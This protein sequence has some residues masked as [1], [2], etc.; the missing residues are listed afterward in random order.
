MIAFLIIPNLVTAFD[1]HLLHINDNGSL[2]FLP[3]GTWTATPFYKKQHGI[4]HYILAIQMMVACTTLWPPW[5]HSRKM[6]LIRS[7]F[8]PACFISIA[9]I[10]STHT[11]LGMGSGHQAHANHLGTHPVIGASLVLAALTQLCA[12][13]LHLSYGADLTEKGS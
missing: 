11:H 2:A 10:L 1:E 9:A 6:Q 13:M 12:S 3:P 4:L 5:R 7:F 8:D